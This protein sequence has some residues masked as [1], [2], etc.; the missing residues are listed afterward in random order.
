MI[1]STDA[2][3]A[4]VKILKLLLG[5]SKINDLNLVKTFPKVDILNRKSLKPFQLNETD[6]G[7]NYHYIT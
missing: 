4:L 7:S 3:K 1:I 2:E 6:G 5:N